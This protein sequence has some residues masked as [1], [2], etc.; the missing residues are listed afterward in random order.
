IVQRLTRLKSN[1]NWYTMA[2]TRMKSPQ[3]SSA[4]LPAEPPSPV[5][6]E[7]SPI[8]SSTTALKKPGAN[9]SPSAGSSPT[10]QAPSTIWLQG[11]QT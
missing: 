2:H 8:T 9:L 3:F 10:R 4:S 1:R 5:F 11:L 7:L 6:C